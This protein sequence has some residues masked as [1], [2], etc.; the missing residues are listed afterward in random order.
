MEGYLIGKSK[1]EIIELFHRTNVYFKFETLL[2]EREF[3][4][5]PICILDDTQALEFAGDRRYTKVK[6]VLVYLDRNKLVVD[7]DFASIQLN[8]ITNND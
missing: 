4:I 5:K 7:V 8:I 3:E 1:K 2:D 6:P